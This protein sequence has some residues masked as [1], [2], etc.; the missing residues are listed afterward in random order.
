MQTQESE[1]SKRYRVLTS[2]DLLTFVYRLYHLGRRGKK[3]TLVCCTSECLGRR[4][5]E[6]RRC[7]FDSV[8]PG[9]PEA[10]SCFAATESCVICTLSWV[11]DWQSCEVS[12]PFDP[13]LLN[14]IL[15]ALY[16]YHLSDLGV[17]DHV[18][19]GLVDSFP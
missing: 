1:R 18:S 12:K 13:L 17:G 3:E 15:D 8:N 14:M 6:Q 16:S 9:L 10:S 4:D 2:L 19:S 7:L 5:V 11:L